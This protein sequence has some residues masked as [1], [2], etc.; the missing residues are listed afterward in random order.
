MQAK[1]GI[2]LAGRS[3]R[4]GPRPHDAANNSKEPEYGWVVRRSAQRI[5]DLGFR[6][7]DLRA[8][9]SPRLTGVRFWAGCRKLGCVVDEVSCSLPMGCKTSGF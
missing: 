3:S 7:G 4:N 1:A 6:L 8:V 9:R 5:Q 2:A